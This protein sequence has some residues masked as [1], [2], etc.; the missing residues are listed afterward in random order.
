M[1]EPQDLIELHEA[2]IESL[3]AVIQQLIDAMAQQNASIEAIQFQ[4][5]AMSKPDDENKIVMPN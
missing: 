4:I 5:L 1:S 3:E 2:R